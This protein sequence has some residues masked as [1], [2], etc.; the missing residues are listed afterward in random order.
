MYYGLL[1]IAEDVIRAHPN[2]SR[3]EYITLL[4]ESDRG[5]GTVF[6]AS[7][8]TGPGRIFLEALIGIVD[9]YVRRDRKGLHESLRIAEGAGLGS[10][11]PSG[12]PPMTILAPVEPVQSY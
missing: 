8:L 6:M 4:S 5:A 7:F 1:F 9:A 2:I 11:M 12:I 10:P 3:D